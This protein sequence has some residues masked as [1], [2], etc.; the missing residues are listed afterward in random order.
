M[1]T[2]EKILTEALAL[3]A[4]KGCS[5][6]C[7]SEI[8][9]AVGIKT[10]SLYKH[11]KSKED[12]FRSCVEVFA[13]RM[14]AIRSDIRLPGSKAPSLSYET[15]SEDQ[16]IGIADA[17]FLFYLRDPVASGFRK[18]LLIERYHNPELNKL[19]EDIFII[20][21]VNYEEAIFSR[22][23]D[24]GIISRG[25]PH[26][27]AIR[28]YSPIFFLLQKYDLRPDETAQAEQELSLLVRD[29]FEKYRAENEKQ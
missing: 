23:M 15:I 16:L 21:A 9:E 11:Y 22:L 18:M 10:P 27:A 2:K 7:L 20:G 13:E 19:Y 14:E 17:L 25:D 1:T 3:F 29:F 4:T 6:V 28:F 8:A 24:A 26:L 5:A 12:L